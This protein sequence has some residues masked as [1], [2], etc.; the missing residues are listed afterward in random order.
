[1]QC[2]FNGVSLNYRL[3]CALLNDSVEL[4][5]LRREHPFISA[6][7]YQ[8]FLKVS[9]ILTKL[10]SQTAYPKNNGSYEYLNKPTTIV[11]A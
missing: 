3:R 10:L 7:S 8:S 2:K 1:M 5:N 6:D 11:I 9:S 4:L